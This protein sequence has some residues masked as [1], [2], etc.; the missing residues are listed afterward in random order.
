MHRS[1]GDFSLFC[2]QFERQAWIVTVVAERQREMGDFADENRLGP[3]WR[4]GQ[5]VEVAK[6][7]D[8]AGESQPGEQEDEGVTECQV[9]V[10]RRQQHDDERY[11]E[12]QAVARRQDEDAPLAEAKRRAAVAVPAEKLNLQAFDQF[13]AQGMATLRISAAMS[14]AVAALPPWAERRR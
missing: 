9:V 1:S 5:S 7:V 2:F 4:D 13:H 10:D 11:R 8:H 6:A 12:E 14:S 3:T